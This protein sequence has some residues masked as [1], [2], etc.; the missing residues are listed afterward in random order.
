MNL[1]EENAKAINAE[2]GV[3]ELPFACDITNTDN[4]KAAVAAGIENKL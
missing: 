3:E 1:L 4:V 2:F